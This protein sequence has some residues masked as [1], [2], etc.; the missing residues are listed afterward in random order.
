MY[1]H[2]Q[3]SPAAIWSSQADRIPLLAPLVNIYDGSI[4][5]YLHSTDNGK[6]VYRNNED[7]HEHV[8][9]GRQGTSFMML[10]PGLLNHK[11]VKVVHGDKTHQEAQYRIIS[12]KGGTRHNCEILRKQ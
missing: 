6:S 3:L 8:T 10:C 9:D 2:T 4:T 5:E 12:A 11:I 7:Y 1:S